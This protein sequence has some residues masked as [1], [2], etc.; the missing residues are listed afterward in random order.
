VKYSDSWIGSGRSF[1]PHEFHV[2]SNLDPDYNGPGHAQLTV[3]LEHSYQNGGRPRLGIQDNKAISVGFGTPPVNLT[4][5]TE[6]R[7]VAGCNGIMETSI[8]SECFALA[9]E[10]P[11]WYNFKQVLGPVVMQANP[12]PGYKGN[13]N[14]VEAYYQMNTIVN[15]VGQ[16]N[17]VMQYWF[18]GTRIINRHDIIFRTGARP[19]LQFQQFVMAPYIGSPGSSVAQGFWID[20][21][22]VASARAQ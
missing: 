21:L 20:N 9:G 19:N 2:L 4:T 11:P 12:G 14:F 16:N 8:T 1:H 18:N 6:S 3:Y 15:G 22:T 13:W 5:L 17:G 10:T 7:S